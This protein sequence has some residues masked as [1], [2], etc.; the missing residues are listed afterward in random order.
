MESVLGGII[1]DDRAA[2]SVDPFQRALT[3]CSAYPLFIE[4]VGESP[5]VSRKIFPPPFSW[6]SSLPYASL[7]WPSYFLRESDPLRSVVCTGLKNLYLTM[8]IFGCFPIYYVHTSV[9]M[10]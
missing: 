8:C 5:Y 9:F 10:Y 3:G 6:T 7:F 4:E 1:G 2:A